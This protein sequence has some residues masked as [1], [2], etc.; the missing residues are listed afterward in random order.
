VKPSALADVVEALR[1]GQPPA[2]EGLRLVLELVES[3]AGVATELR[4]RAALRTWNTLWASGDFASRCA[5]DERVA[6][7]VGVSAATVRWWRCWL[8]HVVPQQGD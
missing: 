1:A 5:V 7:R 4:R 3:E 6:A 2:G 8:D